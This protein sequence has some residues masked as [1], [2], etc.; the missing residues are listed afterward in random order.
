MDCEDYR[1]DV[2]YSLRVNWFP[3]KPGQSLMRASLE[4]ALALV[5]VCWLH[6]QIPPKDRAEDYATHATAGGLALGAEYLV[7][8]IPAGSQTLLA[9]DYLVIDVALFPP[10]DQ[11][12]EIASGTFTLRLNGKKQVLYPVVPG[13][14]AASLKYPDWVVRPN[15]QVTAGVGDA[16]VVLGRP[17][18]VGRFPDDP[19]PGQSRLPRAPRAP[20]PDDQRGIEQEEPESIDQVIARTALPDGPV[21]KPVS[22]YLYFAYKGKIRAIKSLELIYSETRASGTKVESATLK[23]M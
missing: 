17:P 16:G 7:H 21:V 8:S 10:R 5:S 13:F 14:V 3:R 23:L 4:L 1:G 2:A 12:V 18:V 20:T 11:A 9:S 15:A 6:G 19:H 22:G